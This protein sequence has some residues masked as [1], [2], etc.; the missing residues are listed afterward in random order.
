MQTCNQ[1]IKRSVFSNW[2]V[3]LPRFTPPIIVKNTSNNYYCSNLHCMCQLST[4]RIHPN[5]TTQH[6]ELAVKHLFH[7]NKSR[8]HQT[9]IFKCPRCSTLHDNYPPPSLNPQPSLSQ[10]A[11]LIPKRPHL[12][13][14]FPSP[15]RPLAQGLLQ[16]PVILRTLG[17]RMRP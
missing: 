15:P 3:N 17:W 6:N 14:E 7:S 8:G 10:S 4:I 1:T 13:L 11:S 2:L 16:F 5:L 12:R 9:L